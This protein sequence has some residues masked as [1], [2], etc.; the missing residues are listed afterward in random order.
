[1]SLG[2]GDD[3]EK[4]KDMIDVLCPE[5]VVLV[6]PDYLAKRMEEQE[7]TGVGVLS[8]IEKLLDGKLAQFRE[9]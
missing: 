3:E 7:I 8:I 5:R 1:M 9:V 6:I 2:A 4:A